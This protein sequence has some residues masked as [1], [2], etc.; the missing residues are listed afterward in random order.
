MSLRDMARFTK[1]L[2]YFVE[3]GHPAMEAVMLALFF[4][5]Y[6]RFDST[7][8]RDEFVDQLRQVSP[9]FVDF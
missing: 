9:A 4:C 6:C 2:A 1:V 5:Y 7:A 3:E 8:V